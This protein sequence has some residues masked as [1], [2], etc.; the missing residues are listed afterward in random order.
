MEEEC[1]IRNKL[2]AGKMVLEMILKGETPPIELVEI[3]L[4]DLKF[5]LEPKDEK[6]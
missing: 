1:E 5:L 6:S 2:K 3:A 4:H